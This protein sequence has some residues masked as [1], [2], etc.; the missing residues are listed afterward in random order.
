MLLSSLGDNGLVHPE[1]PTKKK[2]DIDKK[3]QD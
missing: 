3:G 1:L 2:G